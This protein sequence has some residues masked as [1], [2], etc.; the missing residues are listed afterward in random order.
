M[1]WLKL[2]TVNHNFPRLINMDWVCEIA[3][4]Y[5]GEGLSET[6]STMIYHDNEK[7]DVIETLD[8]IY[9]MLEGKK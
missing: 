9:K 8:E 1:S 6:G 7:I 3:D 2:H 5:Y 4:Y